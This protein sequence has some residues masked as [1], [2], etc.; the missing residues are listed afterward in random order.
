MHIDPKVEE[1]V[2]QLRQSGGV[3]PAQVQGQPVPVANVN[4]MGWSV[5]N[6]DGGE[7][8]VTQLPTDVVA[9][10]VLTDIRGL[11][12]SL[13]ERFD[14]LEQSFRPFGNGNRAARRGKG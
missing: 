5:P 13:G 3:A 2:R 11:L 10:L 8:T 14:R 6:P 9:V 4:T 7:P 1:A 12:T